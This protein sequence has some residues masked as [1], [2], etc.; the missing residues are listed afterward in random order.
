[1]I[2]SFN[3]LA[4]AGLI[5]D[6]NNELL[7]TE[8]FVWTE[9]INV[10]F[11]D[12][13]VRKINGS[14]SVFTTPIVPYYAAYISDNQHDYIVIAGQTKIYSYYSGAW[15]DI[16]NVVADY[17]PS[18]N[19]WQFTVINTFPVF[20]NTVDVPQVWSPALPGTP[21][22]NLP[23]WPVD[24][25]CGIMRSFKAYLIAGNIKDNATMYPTRVWWSGSALPGALPTSW[26][27][28]DPTEDAGYTDLSD[29]PGAIVDMKI[30][31]DN[32][33]IYKQRA[34]YM[35]YYVG[36]NNIFSIKQIF[37]NIGTISKDCICEV[38]GQHLVITMDDIIM[39]DG[40]S[41]KSIVDGRL[42]QTIFNSINLNAS[43][44]CHVVPN[45]KQ[46]EVWI[47]VPTTGTYTTLVYIFNYETSTWTTRSVSATP[48]IATM[49]LDI[50]TAATF[51]ASTSTYNSANYIYDLSQ[52]YK[53]KYFMT[54]V[55]TANNRLLLL[56]STSNT[57][58]GTNMTVTIERKNIKLAEDESIKIVKRIWPKMTKLSGTSDI[59][60]FYIGTQLTRNGTISWS[61]AMPFNITTGDKLD[62]FATGR[63][64]SI[65]IE[66]TTDIDWTIENF[67]LDVVS[68]GKW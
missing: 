17:N 57:E 37:N 27:V 28:T 15:T 22:I 64:L 65:R 32:L 1:M 46:S 30:L 10:R 68:G 13:S 54:M 29:T 49:P 4:S 8:P 45:Y 19:N 41:Y 67:E 16:T 18:A 39:T 50:S 47:C 33:I 66:S 20:N 2:L 53:S 43:M 48:C 44:N 35:M 42:R 61:A 52:Y 38:K 55:D 23:E 14:E 24:T 31:G 34:V 63:W 62:F 5:K 6:T 9:A 26:D 3:Q 59:V 58:V 12:G 40:N 56:D 60:N 7:P 36:G 25:R 51:N 21:L 11:K